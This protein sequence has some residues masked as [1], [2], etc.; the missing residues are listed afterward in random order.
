MR[1]NKLFP[2]TLGPIQEQG[3]EVLFDYMCR[4]LVCLGVRYTRLDERDRSDGL[5]YVAQNSFFA[6][7]VGGRWYLATAGHVL[8]QLDRFVTSPKVRIRSLFLAGFRRI[9]EVAAESMDFP[10]EPGMGFAVHDRAAGIDVGCIPLG[11]SCAAALGASGVRPLAQGHWIRPVGPDIRAYWMLGLPAAVGEQC[12]RPIPVGEEQTRFATPVLLS[13]D[14][15]AEK[16][17]PPAITGWQTSTPGFIGRI[18]S[19][20]A[21]GIKGMSGGPIFGLFRSPNG[22]VGYTVVALQS[23]WH[24]TTRTIFGS[25]IRVFSELLAK[26]AARSEVVP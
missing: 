7:S 12:N 13:A 8:Q 11:D 5:E 20:I 15:I 23:C 18:N 3:L 9:P 21:F 4:H 1:R 2:S 6:T 26:E 19:E 10:Y 17:I 24:A 14:R 25:P 22:L 16:D